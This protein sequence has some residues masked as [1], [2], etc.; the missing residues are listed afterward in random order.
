[1]LPPRIAALGDDELDRRAFRHAVLHQVGYEQFGTRAFDVAGFLAAHPDRPALPTVF[2]AVEE[3]RVDAAIVHRF[4]GA[5]GDVAR[6][7]TLDPPAGPA[8][9]VVLDGLD[10]R[11]DLHRWTRG[12]RRC[13]GAGAVPG[14]R[15]R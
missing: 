4:P 3:R 10:R 5:A 13:A 7:R 15:R 14:G 6:A 8:L 9:A 12:G 2:A 1:M 11:T